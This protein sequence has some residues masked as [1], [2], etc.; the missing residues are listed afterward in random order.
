M[1]KLEFKDL[2]FEELG[3][4]VKVSFLNN[5]YFYL[6]KDNLEKIGKFKIQKSAI[7]F[8]V[9]EKRAEGRFNLLLSIGF[10]DLKN[11]LT[12]RK[13]VYITKDSGIPLIGNNAFGL[14]DR[15][16]SLIEVKPCTGCNLNCIYC[17][18]DEGKSGKWVTD[19]LVEP[20]YLIEEFRKLVEFKETEVEAHIGTQGEPFLYPNILELIK[21][22]SSTKNVKLISL[23]TNGTMLTKE[24]IN[25]LAL[26]GLSRINL[27]I[28]A[29]DEKLAS[30]I[31][32]TPYNLKHVLDMVRYTITRMK[33]LIAPVW[34]PGIN[35]KEIPKLIELSK[36]L[37]I[38]IGIQNFLNYKYGR[39]PVKAMNWDI[40]R[41]KMK[42][43]ENEQGVKLLL[44]EK[45]F[46][47]KKT[48]K[49]PKPFKKGQVVKANVVC[50]GRLKNEKIAV[51]NQRSIAVPNC[52]KTGTI[53]TKITRDKHNIFF[54]RCL[55]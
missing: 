38:T 46:G 41:D 10:K 37:G 29:L 54:G 26:A 42:K 1:A 6:N 8:D 21:G 36:D 3:N 33:L 15:N 45:D 32:G 30:K 14:V 34:L 50:G 43:L 39:N 17:S 11:K 25:N 24:L 9:P 12:N 52:Y 23:D 53:K 40:F 13:T 5:Y 27:S 51:A 31:A 55:G 7:S 19:F 44:T 35:D 4:K 49:L 16:T 48:K 22:L 18:V 2:S 28:N 20:D 47:I